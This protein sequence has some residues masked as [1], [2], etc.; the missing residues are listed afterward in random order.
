MKKYFGLISLAIVSFVIG[1]Y[2]YSWVN[3]VPSVSTL[4]LVTICG[5]IIS[6]LIAMLGK[7][8]VVKTLSISLILIFGLPYFIIIEFGRLYFRYFGGP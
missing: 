3:Y 6:F 4:R 1:F 5:L 8:G 2:I 7:S